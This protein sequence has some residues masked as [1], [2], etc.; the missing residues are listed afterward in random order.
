M[1]LGEVISH[2]KNHAKKTGSSAIGRYQFMS[3][4]LEDLAKK[5]NL[6]LNDKFSPEL[7]DRL[8]IS[9]LEDK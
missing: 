2:S 4:T 8:A 3:Y 1:T 5:Y 6:N 7:Q 9:L